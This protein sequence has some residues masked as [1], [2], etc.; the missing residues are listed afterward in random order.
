MDNQDMLFTDDELLTMISSPIPNALWQKA[1]NAYNSDKDNVKLSMYCRPCFNKVL[2][3]HLKF[4][5]K[6]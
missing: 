1:F 6:K 3:Y 2:I 4:R 5:F